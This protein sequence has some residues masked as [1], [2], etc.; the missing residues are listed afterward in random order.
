M[1]ASILQNNQIC[2]L[3]IIIPYKYKGG[4]EALLIQISSVHLEFQSRYHLFD[5]EPSIKEIYCKYVT[6]YYSK[7]CIYILSYISYVGFE[8]LRSNTSRA[9]NNFTEAVEKFLL[10]VIK[11]ILYHCKQKF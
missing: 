7:Y 10:S 6:T 3:V 11:C 9:W 1:S 2:E 5:Q 8:V 4:E